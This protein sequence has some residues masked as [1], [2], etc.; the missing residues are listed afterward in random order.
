MALGHGILT[1]DI[2]L[3]VRFDVTCSMHIEVLPAFIE[4]SLT[5]GYAGVVKAS[6]TRENRLLNSRGTASRT[7][8]EGVGTE[9]TENRLVFS[10]GS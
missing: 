6:D 3:F 7:H 1:T 10:N 8:C 5:T 9:N 4:I 2:Q